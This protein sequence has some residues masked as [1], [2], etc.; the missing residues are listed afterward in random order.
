MRLIV[1]AAGIAGLV[2][3]LGTPALIKFLRQHGYSQAIRESTDDV[4][5]PAHEGK[6]GTPSMGG[7]AIIGGLL[8][9]YFGTHLLFWEPPTST[10][11]LALY[12]TVGLGMVG[13]AD[14]YLKIFKQ[15]S[16]GIRARTKLLGQAFVAISFAVMAV[17][18]PDEYGQTPAS[19]AISF[20]RDLGWGLPLGLF[21]IWIWLLV[22]A[23]TNGVNLTDGLDGL[24]SGAALVTFVA[25]LLMT[26][27]QFNNQCAID[28]LD[29]CYTVRD[30]LD[31]G[32]FAA[33][34]AGA[35]FGFLWWNTSPA[36]IFMGDTGSLAL[37]GA[38]A[39]L[40]IMTRT[41]LLLLL[42]GGLFVVITVSVILQV[43]SF[44]LTGKRVFRMAPLHHHFELLGWPEI[45][46]VVRFWIIHALMVGLGL[47]IFYA[48]WVTT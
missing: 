27:W 2:S 25:Y 16:T 15:R 12:L 32:V 26:V 8:F 4:Q 1:L 18:F 46:I 13:M 37:G 10:G 28:P 43:G 30:P 20:L 48:E 7:L 41:E 24:A 11:L 35:V 33:A 42:L 3:L 19:Q 22:T 31:L 29:P 39:A 6:V 23:T 17:Q 9:G 14:D 34:C 47:T 40:A 36:S 38:I 5:Y 21:V 45:L 44:K